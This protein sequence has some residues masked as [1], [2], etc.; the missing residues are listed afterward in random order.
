[1]VHK[2]MESAALQRG[3]PDSPDIV[4]VRQPFQG[5]GTIAEGEIRTRGGR[6]IVSVR[7]VRP[8]AYDMVGTAL[9]VWCTRSLPTS[10]LLPPSPPP[11]VQ[12]TIKP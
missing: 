10:L 9:F 5:F 6:C 8:S 2:V 12:R 1:M 11:R 7:P 4:F 3:N